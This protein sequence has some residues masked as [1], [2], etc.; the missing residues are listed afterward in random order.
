[1]TYGKN[2]IYGI[3]FCLKEKPDKLTFKVRYNYNYTEITN[4][5][6]RCEPERKLSQKP[7]NQ[8]I[9]AYIQ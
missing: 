6:L 3:V 9:Q 7:K 4:T 5:P 2:M 8:P 1:M